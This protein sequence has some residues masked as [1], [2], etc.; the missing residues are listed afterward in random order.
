MP[1]D[2]TDDCPYPGKPGYDG[3]LAPE[4]VGLAACFERYKV[5]GAWSLEPELNMATPEQAAELAHIIYEL[6]CE[7]IRLK[8]QYPTVRLLWDREEAP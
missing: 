8:A 3:A 2:E 1:C 4:N 5:L 7:H 6:E